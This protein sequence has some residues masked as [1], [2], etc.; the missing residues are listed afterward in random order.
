MK[1]TVELHGGPGDGHTVE[2]E[3]GQRHVAFTD[4]AGLHGYL[5]TDGRYVWAWSGV[6]PSVTAALHL[7]PDTAPVRFLFTLEDGST[8]KIKI[9]AKQPP[10]EPP[11][12]ARVVTML[13]QLRAN[14]ERWVN[15]IFAVARSQEGGA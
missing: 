10:R 7:K 4:E 11:E 14:P 15:A 5:L 13:N 9:S 1:V 6:R 2:V 3:E 12:T 8:L